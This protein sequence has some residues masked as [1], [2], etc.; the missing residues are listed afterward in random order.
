MS[1]GPDSTDNREMLKRAVFKLDEL[2]AKLDRLNEPIA[3]IGLSCRFPG[4]ANDPEAL[5]QVL[6]DGVDAITE[7]PA[8]RWDVETYYD[9]TPGTPG[10]M[11]GRCG[12]FLESVDGFDPH[13]FGIAP[14]EALKM[15][16][17][18][19]LL[20]EV[21]WEA[22]ECAGQA[23]SRLSESPTG[24][25]VG[26][27]GCDY[28]SLQAAH[29]DLAVIDTY[30]ASGVSLSIASGRISYLLGLRGP[31]L[32]IDTA[33][34]SS[35]VAVHLACQS[36]R[37]GECD[38][39]LAGGVNLI[40]TPAGNIA[41]C[42]ARMLSPD[43]RCKTFDASA[44]GY[45]RAEGCAVVVL[46]RLSDAQANGDNILALIRGT[47]ANQ[48]GRSN[49]LTAPNGAA[50]EAV[51]REA[52][53]KSQVKPSAVSYV[54]A[55]GTG[56]S[57]GDPI[58]VQ[59][60]GAVL[61]EDRS[62]GAPLL[63]GAVKTN[64]GHPEAVSGIAGLLKVILA[65][66]HK[67]IPATLHVKNLNPHVPWDKL[68]LKVVTQLTPWPLVTGSRIAGVSSFGFSGTNVHLLVEEAPALAPIQA[69]AERPLHLFTL[70]AKTET[71]L[72]TLAS[73]FARHLE[74]DPKTRV[75][76]IC[77]TA[78]TGRSHFNY[79]LTASAAS[80]EQLGEKL[81]A[82]DNGEFLNGVQSGHVDGTLQP[83]IVFLF[84]GQGAQYVGMGRQL[85]ETQPT[86]RRTLDTSD[87]VLRPYLEQP[88]LSVLYPDNAASS[89]L[90][91]TCYTQPAL[92]AIEYAL[93]ELW[94]SWGIV[95]SVVM[96]HSV[97]EYAAACVAGAFSLEEGLKFI[98]ERGRLM[99]ALP[100]NGKMA[101]VFAGGESVASAIARYTDRV[102]IA[103]LNGPEN[104]V[105]SGDGER[106][107]EILHNLEQQGI[108]SKL[109]TVSH[110]FHS[111]LLEPIL[112]EFERVAGEVAYS[113]PRIGLVSNLTGE[114]FQPRD[115]VDKR[116][117]RRH[118]REGVEFAAG[119]KTLHQQGY[120]IFVEIGPDATLLTM[121]RRC[122]P[123]N[124]A[125]WVPSLRQGRDDWQQ[126]LE[127][128][129]AL[130]IQGVDID[131]ANFDRGYSRRRVI[132]PVYPFERERY[133]P[134]APAP[135]FRVSTLQTREEEQQQIHPL[136]GRLLRSALKQTQFEN[137][138]SLESHAFLK[139]HQFF[140]TAVFPASAYMEMALAAATQVFKST[141]CTL[142][143][144]HFREALLIPDGKFITMQLIAM[145]EDAGRASF[146]IYSLANVGDKG[147]SAWKLHVTGKMAVDSRGAPNERVSLEELLGRCKNQIAIE[148]FYHK[149]DE[150]GVHY[151]PGFRCIESL[152][153]FGNESL[154]RVR[155]S[156]SQTEAYE[157]HPALLDA[158]IQVFGA[159]L[160][161]RAGPN[162]GD[163]Y[164]PITFD[165]VRVF[166]SGKRDVW[167]H[168]VIEEGGVGSET[169]VGSLRLLDDDGDVITEVKGMHFKRTPRESLLRAM[170]KRLDGWFYELAWQPVTTAHV[171][172][173]PGGRGAWVVL[174]DGSGV[175]V[176]LA[177]LFKQRK[178]EFVLVFPAESLERL[179]DGNWKI[180]P[181]R[182]E[183]FQR[184]LKDVTSSTN[185]ECR[186]VIHLWGLGSSVVEE[187]SVADMRQQGKMV[188]GTGLHLVHALVNVCSAHLPRLWLVTRGAQPVDSA[189]SPA[190][191][192]GSLWGL[193]AVIAVEHPTL[194]CTRVDLDPACS[195]ATDDDVVRLFAE[196][197]ANVREN[198][199]AIRR[200][201]TYA[202]RFQRCQ[203][204][205][206]ARVSAS[207][208]TG[209]PKRLDIS[210][211]GSLDNLKLVPASRRN[212][213][214]GEVEIRVLATGLNFRDV[215]N[216]LDLYPGDAGHLGSECAGKIVAVGEGV[217]GLRV[218]DEVV[219]M[220][221][222]SF[223]TYVTT[224]SD[225]V[226]P[227]PASI[228][229][230][231]AASI[232]I[233]FLT[234]EYSLT[235]VGKMSAGDRVL[236]HAG[237]GGVGMAAVQLA[238]RA[239]AGIFA[240]AGSPEKRAFLKS[241][242]VQHVMDS[243]SLAF[244]DD[245]MR[246]TNNEGID[247]VLN[248]LTGEFI[249]KS[250]Q[251]LRAGGRFL[252]IGKSGIWDA[253]KVAQFKRDIS[254]HVIYLGQILEDDPAFA[255]LMFGSL[256]EKL[257]KGRL[258]PLP[259][260]AF[261]LQD[262]VEGFRHM[263]R[264]KHIGKVVVTQP[265]DDAEPDAADV[266]LRKLDANASYMITG[267]LGALGLHVAKWMVDRGARNLLLLGRREPSP[268]ARQIIDQL[269][270]SGARLRV[271]SCDVASSE[272]VRK[273]FDEV[274][275]SSMPPL[276]GIVHSA[277]VLDDDTLLH[278]NWNRF[279]TVFAPKIDGSWNLHQFSKNLRLDFFVLFSSISSVFGAPAQGN[280]SAAN[281]FMDALAHYRRKLGLP[282]LSI[283]WGAWA[284]TG[285]AASLG[286]S[287]D[288]RMARL[289]LTAIAAEPGM[290][291][292]ERLLRNDYTQATVV[293]IDWQKFLSQFRPGEVPPF[294]SELNREEPPVGDV[295]EARTP[296]VGISQELKK[297]I[298]KGDVIAVDLAERQQILVSYL[299]DQLARLLGLSAGK[300]ELQEPLLNLGFDSLMAVE[301]KS[302]IEA[303]FA[304]IV[305]VAHLLQGSSI[306]QLATQIVDQLGEA[307]P[308]VMSQE[309]LVSTSG[310]NRWDVLKI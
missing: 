109:L 97:G 180:D 118:M 82:F 210:K 202:C 35:L 294:F 303:D 289:G 36:L 243:R 247:I 287:G 126:L 18:H 257:A 121:G 181:T 167:C 5:W 218:G 23:P 19:R 59:A 152:A 42:Q 195:R 240:T 297:A 177:E 91:E 226:L 96:G 204:T 16:P 80:S 175:G 87:A 225:F 214:S 220:A 27:S 38:V 67:S 99:Q 173:Q 20:L 103:A 57:L 39:A 1:S 12:G 251:L 281:A 117:W 277:G 100:A 10:K 37:L 147:R 200:G 306:A 131:W 122:V 101:V 300:L 29:A 64:L 161:T 290:E 143:D 156:E 66:Q 166:K 207:G 144:V 48:D 60:L 286:S 245:V 25:F 7:I 293:P 119:I 199:I 61:G 136:L 237:A 165:S 219:A 266:T 272:D 191:L 246:I 45:V 89:P 52:L 234:A 309:Q 190:V 158:C 187:T 267:G 28:A 46:K 140:G 11:Y 192:Q 182:P 6:H 115:V 90:N 72:K 203:L 155:L 301:L 235:H 232:P 284:E 264:A 212:P 274:A 2:Q 85:Y 253:S 108:K 68:P 22:L 172:Q 120:K 4:N 149:L 88:L 30:F 163:A 54:E 84:A 83:E 116:Y 125:V 262:A 73:R 258:K 132:L 154:G 229:M 282:A 75:S 292:M 153:D 164:M 278:L 189:D 31:S 185:G 276:R 50:Q 129:A 123:N 256:L 285:M 271:H 21:T 295:D 41:T 151:G 63:I 33:C 230:E 255:R 32:S 138:I 250:L 8:E 279:A 215:L 114:L 183:D 263:A 223:A 184:L 44:D 186:G 305:S 193:G 79:R 58:E 69:E 162:A 310:D 280:Y 302:R 169:I 145:P 249:P 110:A 236:I 49:G 227:K 283:N 53:A 188:C 241:I 141:T 112:D 260:R 137:Q 51:I 17:Q 124:G 298:T 78:N 304:V 221:S 128:L 148:P 15:D 130:Y 135:R 239:G 233:T 171:A 76:D 106:V 56:T 104:T 26:I 308:Q 47:A 159:T 157:I 107:C 111:P 105:I 208:V 134:K 299:V 13:F 209:V 261:T 205:D 139:D 176:K 224:R 92:F 178:E 160:V 102:S 74:L 9:P 150:V 265:S 307:I 86:F 206:E 211:R 296:S 198:Q 174:A 179:P 242:G 273:L 70:S 194:W 228:T 216:T 71:A 127:T 269:E 213:G 270:A 142:E 14:R 65:L 252:E 254:Y 288:K 113:P 291:A 94:K 77:F 217:E 168:A 40:L 259:L 95:P 55:H 81:S 146:E 98:A 197:S 196:I 62:Q 248:S 222:D 231:E 170:Q 268:A 275:E 24:V 34:S 201:Q 93:A 238:Q 244:G 133:W 43:G 3:V